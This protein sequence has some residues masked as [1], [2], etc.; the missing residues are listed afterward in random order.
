MDRQEELNRTG[1]VHEAWADK[2]AAVPGFD[3]D[4][5]TAEQATDLYNALKSEL[6]SVGKGEFADEIARMS[7]DELNQL[8]RLS[9]YQ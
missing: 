7:E 9:I 1:L 8:R 2:Y 4:N 5:P 6:G 3:P